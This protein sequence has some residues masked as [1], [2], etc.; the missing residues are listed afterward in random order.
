MTAIAAPPLLTGATSGLEVDPDS[1]AGGSD[2]DVLHVLRDPT[3]GNTVVQQFGPVNDPGAAVA[4]TGADDTHGAGAGFTTTTGL[5]IDSATNR[6][7]VS[8]TA[9]TVGAS[10][11]RVYVLGEAPAPTA[12]IDS[13][14]TA[15]TSATVEG[16]IDANGAQTG[17][18]FEFSTDGGSTWTNRP[19]G[20][21]LPVGSGDDAEDVSYQL[22][23]LDPGTDY[24]V[25]LVAKQVFGTAAGIS[26]VETFTT[27]AAAPVVGPL[28]ADAGATDA[29]LTG[30]ID[31]SGEATT[32]RFE[33]GPTTD[34]GNE[35][36]V[37]DGDLPAGDAS[38]PVMAD[39][40]DLEPATTYHYRL[41][42][43]NDTGVT[44]GADHVFA[45]GSELSSSCPNED[46]RLGA[47]SR[48][49]GCRAYEQV[50][51][52]D[53][54]GGDVAWTSGTVS[55]GRTVAEDGT[56]AMFASLTEFAGGPSGGSLSPS[57]YVARRTTDGWTTS[58][59]LTRSEPEAA[60]AEADLSSADLGRSLL[61][62][63]GVLESDPPDPLNLDINLYMRDNDAG[64]TS[65]FAAIAETSGTGT[66]LFFAPVASPDMESVVFV[67]T[68][69][70]TADPGIPTS[71]FTQKVYEK[72]GGQIRLVSV[73]PDG[74]PVPSTAL[75]AGAP[76]NPGTPSSTVGGV[77]DDGDHV[78]FS[79]FAGSTPDAVYR[80]DD[81]ATTALVSPSQREVADP[82]GARGKR[83]EFATPDGDRVFF[84]SA[85]MLTDDA[86]TGPGPTR[87][88]NDLYRY[89]VEDDELVD[90]SAT[91][92]GNGADVVH[93]LGFDDAGDR[94][95]YVARGA[96][97]PGDGP[98]GDPDP[99]PGEPNVYLWEDDGTARGTTR[100]VAT[101]SP[102]DSSNWFN[103]G[104]RWTARTTP[105][106]AQLVFQS[107]A[108]LPGS[109]GAG[110][111]QVYRYDTEAGGGAGE[112]VCVSCNPSGN[113]PIG[114][115][116]VPRHVLSDGVQRWELPRALS[117]DGRRVFF[118]SEDALVPGDSNGEI[119]A[120]MWEDG[121]VN[122]LST[123][124]S[125]TESHFYNA[126]RS[127]DD[128]FI[129][130]DQALVTQDKDDLVDLYDARVG[131]GFPSAPDRPDCDGDECQEG[132]M[133]PPPG[134]AGSTDIHS[135]GDVESRL[136]L[137][138]GLRRPAGTKLARLVR[139]R[140][141]G[142]R[143]HVTRSAKVTVVVRARVGGRRRIV[144][145]GRA[146]ARKAGNVVVG[147][148]LSKQARRQLGRKGAMSLSLRASAPGARSQS[149]T[150]R[151]RTGR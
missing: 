126:S 58:P 68:A 59:M 148:R 85:E 132:S 11:H 42:A 13:V 134:D 23:G 114:P 51:P 8:T 50:S 82:A 28:S 66:G 128:A 111:V 47:S 30:R 27:D 71:S 113:Q 100:L 3:T 104:G 69:V 48:L 118:D 70:L 53:K 99:V 142:L 74:T 78:F 72:A 45:T 1:D 105:D 16:S 81:G 39:I 76:R 41:V 93:V 29:T 43:E 135:A 144:A 12:S 62:S 95:Y 5:G 96:V 139:G 107:E 60:G 110:V 90:I 67:S 33:Y 119:D 49:P 56:K 32:Y 94:V 26:N 133:V 86:N 123:G 136:R 54:N 61:K 34:Y 19:T 151:L 131:G 31:P 21:D 121:E 35:A 77:S 147:L 57:P 44:E 116:S 36:P 117:E 127:G 97:V 25:R 88:G 73:L 4:P 20:N 17:Y 125:E 14:D 84:S 122:L 38:V 63:S 112:L 37:P 98:G 64:V 22:E 103:L 141:V 91:S 6:L 89:D 149:L 83:F 109:G 120:Y 10:G 124:T 40:S 80:R 9:A 138:L 52:V 79:S 115:S 46:L 65:P 150:L 106:G 140:K 130:T 7:F 143:V 24:S 75:P 18:H 2:E 129:L 101:L 102:A 137:V 146:R 145:R 15:S 108:S 92:G 87:P 55:G